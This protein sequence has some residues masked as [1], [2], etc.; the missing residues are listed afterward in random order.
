LIYFLAGGT[1][2]GNIIS[3]MGTAII[4]LIILMALITDR[5]IWHKEGDS[6]PIILLIMIVFT[7]IV[8]SHLLTS[9]ATLAII[10]ALALARRDIRLVWVTIGCLAILLAWDLTVAGDYIIPKLP[11]IGEGEFIFSFNILAEREITGHLIGVGSHADV[12]IVRVLHAALFLLI[13]FAGFI[14]S[15]V[16]KRDIKATVSLAVVTLVPIPLAI[17]SGY[18]AQEIITRIYGFIM[19]GIAYFSTRLLDINKKLVVVVMCLLLILAVPMKLVSAYGNQEFDYISPAQRTGTAFFHAETSRGMV[20]GAW[21]LGDAKNTE[22][23]TNFELH[24]LEWYDNQ[25]PT[26]GWLLEYGY[27]NFYIGIN[28]QDRANYEWIKEN[29]E[30]IINLKEQLQDTSNANLLYYNPD[31]SIYVFYED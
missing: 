20:F 25:I 5:R 6:R 26:P 29:P 27:E 9:L 19:P 28:R 30:F 4:L 31:L 15:L 11:F 14:S 16:G 12:A 21:P 3:A 1:G 8:M 7:A 17:L 18:Y 24:L 22:N 13:G 2:A 23:Y 10:G